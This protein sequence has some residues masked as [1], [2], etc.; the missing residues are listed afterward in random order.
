M[1]TLAL[2]E[3]ITNIG[4][5]YGVECHKSYPAYSNYESSCL[6]DSLHFK[7]QFLNQSSQ[8]RKRRVTYQSYCND[9]QSVIAHPWKA[10]TSSKASTYTVI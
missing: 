3:E 9:C 5:I 8:N 1:L 7:I 10:D 2:T 4:N 6:K